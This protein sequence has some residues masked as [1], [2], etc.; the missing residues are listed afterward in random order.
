MYVWTKVLNTYIYRIIN[1]K[2]TIVTF[3]PYINK[4]VVI[5]QKC[6]ASTDLVTNPKFV[7]VWIINNLCITQVEDEMK[8][9]YYVNQFVK[10]LCDI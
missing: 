8:N 5:H 6:N 10:Y 2:T 3:N 9:T 7:V 1:L 4:F